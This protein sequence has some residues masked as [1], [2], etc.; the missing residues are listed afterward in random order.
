MDIEKVEY[1]SITCRKNF[2]HDF[3][4]PRVDIE[5]NKKLIDV[6]VTHEVRIRTIV[7]IFRDNK[8]YL[9]QCNTRYNFDIN[10]YVLNPV[11]IINID[12][13]MFLSK[14]LLYVENIK[15]NYELDEFAILDEEQINENDRICL[16]ARKMEL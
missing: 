6:V 15:V 3:I 9:L 5:I 4:Y 2:S 8:Y 10:K 1:R 14:F 12:V 11:V 13:S 16:E 7:R